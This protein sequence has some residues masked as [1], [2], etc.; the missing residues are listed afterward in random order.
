MAKAKATPKK[1]TPTKDDGTITRESAKTPPA[2]PTPKASDVENT[3]SFT[4]PF[5]GDAH[6]AAEYF[7]SS[8]GEV[9]E[10]I[11]REESSTSDGGVR[12]TIT[13]K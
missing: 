11:S 13:Y 5:K 10:E 9:K 1:E 4:P 7:V 2:P 8:K 3:E 6:S 12:V